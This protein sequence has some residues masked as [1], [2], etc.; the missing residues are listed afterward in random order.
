LTLELEIQDLGRQIQVIG[1]KA[2]HMLTPCLS[3]LYRTVRGKIR[4]L[5]T[6][7]LQ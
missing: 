3:G 6:A 1:K 2:L 4:I 5:T 7:I